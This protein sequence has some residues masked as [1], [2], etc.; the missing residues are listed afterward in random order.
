MRDVGS[1][2]E[3]DNNFFKIYFVSDLFYY[4]LYD[5]ILCESTFIHHNLLFIYIVH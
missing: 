2:P 5:L 4:L 3:R 1:I